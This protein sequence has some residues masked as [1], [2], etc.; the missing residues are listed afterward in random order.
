[1]EK[2]KMEQQLFLSHSFDLL[3]KQLLVTHPLWFIFVMLLTHPLWFIFV[4]IVNDVN[5]CCAGVNDV[6]VCVVQVLLT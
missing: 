1:V 3:I 5:V 2:K 4:S 6:N